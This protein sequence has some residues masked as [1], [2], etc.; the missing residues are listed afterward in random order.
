MYIK[1]NLLVRRING[2]LEDKILLVLIN[3][4]DFDH[5]TLPFRSSD[6]RYPPEVRAFIPFQVINPCSSVLKCSRHLYR[7]F[8]FGFSTGSSAAVL[9][10]SS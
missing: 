1:I 3:L 7:I 9:K 5:E 8:F 10:R 6:L 4:I 2:N